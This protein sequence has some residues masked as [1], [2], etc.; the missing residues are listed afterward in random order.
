MRLHHRKPTSSLPETFL[1]VQK[2][3][4]MDAARH[5]THES[6]HYAERR[7][8]ELELQVAQEVVARRARL[9]DRVLEP[10]APLRQLAHLARAREAALLQVLELG[11]HVLHDPAHRVRHG[12]ESELR[13][14]DVDTPARARDAE[15]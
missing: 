7:E 15:V 9:R 2:S 8:V 4:G 3:A 13:V 6:G 11:H 10:L 5:V 14:R 12:E 1:T